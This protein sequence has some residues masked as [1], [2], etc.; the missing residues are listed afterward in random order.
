[1]ADNH[2]GMSFEGKAGID[3]YRYTLLASSLRL[4]AKTGLKPT[5]GIGGKQ[6]MAMA[7][8]LTG[9]KFKARQYMEAA[10]RLEAV[11]QT[12][13]TDNPGCVS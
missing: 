11:A 6:M 13:A 10:E 3:V 2:E 4:F 5:R 8:E 9:V 12:I 7:T 1:M